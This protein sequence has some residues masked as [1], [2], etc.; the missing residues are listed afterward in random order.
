MIHPWRRMARF[1]FLQSRIDL[2]ALL[3][4][5]PAPTKGE[6]VDGTDSE[7]DKG[8]GLGNRLPMY[9]ERVSVS[10]VVR[11]RIDLVL[12]DGI[13]FRHVSPMVLVTRLC[14]RHDRRQQDP[15]SIS[16]AR[17]T[18]SMLATRVHPKEK[19]S[20]R[21]GRFRSDAGAAFEIEP[22]GCTNLSMTDFSNLTNIVIRC[23]V[24]DIEI[25]KIPGNCARVYSGGES[26]TH[27]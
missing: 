14:P 12:F 27:Y 21:A 10:E 9:L 17:L 2:G 18:H 5:L 4:S 15:A 3:H 7:E 25:P 26:G 8:R 19:Q 11:H 6:Q 23:Q 13:T 1:A 20:T 24:S 22:K 16:L